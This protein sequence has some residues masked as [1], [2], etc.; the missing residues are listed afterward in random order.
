MLGI[1]GAA[2]AKSKEESDR[3]I[4][5]WYDWTRQRENRHY[6]NIKKAGKLRK[7]LNKLSAKNKVLRRK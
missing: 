3:E 4:G 1:I 7:R 6:E 5:Y 2:L